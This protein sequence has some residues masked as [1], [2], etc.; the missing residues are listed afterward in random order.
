M[1]DGLAFS[2]IKNDNRFE[3]S[4]TDKTPGTTVSM[5]ISTTSKLSLADVFNEYADPDKQPGFYKTAIPVQ[6]MQY[7]GDSLMSR[8]NA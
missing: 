2:W 3:F 4:D 1:T 7:E 8:Q 5:V 6:I